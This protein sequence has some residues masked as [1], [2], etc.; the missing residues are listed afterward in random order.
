MIKNRIARWKTEYLGI[1]GNLALP[2]CMRPLL[3][4]VYF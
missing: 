1:L 2:I 3:Q 4:I